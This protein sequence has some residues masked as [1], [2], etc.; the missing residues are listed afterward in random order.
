[1][2]KSISL[3]VERESIPMPSLGHH[4]PDKTWSETDPMGHVHRWDDNGEIPTVNRLEVGM[5][6]SEFGDELPIIEYRCKRCGHAVEPRWN[7]MST[8]ALGHVAGPVRATMEIDTDRARYTFDLSEEELKLA[9]EAARTGKA[10][11]FAEDLI[12]RRK[13]A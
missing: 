7:W 13:T 1:M 4:Q 10:G 6:L 3:N 12:K 5:E 11:A 9:E 8:G 2:I